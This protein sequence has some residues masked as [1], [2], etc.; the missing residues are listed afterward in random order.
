MLVH[1]WQFRDFTVDDA[2]ISF[3][4]ARNLAHGHGLVLIPGGER[5]EA[6]SNFFWVLCLAVGSAVG[7]DLFVWAHLLGALCAVVTILGVAALAAAV[8]GKPSPLD[9]IPALLA[10]SL[11]PIPYWAM[12][13]LEGGAYAA[14]VVWCATALARFADDG[15]QWRI[16]AGLAAGLALMR[17]DGSVLLGGAALAFWLVPS[18]WSTRLRWLAVAIGPVVV[19]LI[20]RRWYYAY[21]LPNTFYAKVATPF[22]LGQL[23]HLDAPGWRYVRGFVVRYRL[24]PLLLPAVL[25]VLPGPRAR[26]ARGAIILIAGVA[27]FPLY[28]GADWMSE[29][30]FLAPAL[31]L[32]CALGFS[33]I[34]R[35][36]AWWPRRRVATVA[37]WTALAGAWIVP[38]TLALSAKRRGN[39]PAPVEVVATRARFYRELAARHAIANAS[40]LDGDLGATSLYA[41]MPIVDLGLLGDV[42]LARW[43]ADR[44]VLREYIHHERE[45][46]FLRLQGFWW[47]A[48]VQDAPEF[49][50][51]YGP[52]PGQPGLFVDRRAFSSP[53]IDTRA[54]LASFSRAGIDVVGADTKPA[55]VTLR[56][57]VRQ[58]PTIPL[59]LRSDGGPS[60]AVTH[61]LLPMDRWRPGDVVNVSLARPAGRGLRLC[62]GEDCFALP[63]GASGAA[64][65]SARPTEQALALARAREDWDAAL[66]VALARGDATAEIAALLLTRAK[67]FDR[68]GDTARAFRDYA[69]ALRGDPSLAGARRRMEELRLAARAHLHAQ[70]ERKHDEAA[71]TFRL[72]PTAEHLAT[73]ALLD[74]AVGRS[75]AAR[76]HLATGV[77]PTDDDGALALAETLAGHGFREASL[78]L[79]PRAA[80]PG[81]PIW[82]RAA[83]VT[84]R[85][86]APAGA[87]PPSETASAEI[88]PGLALVAAWGEP[89]PD[90]QIRLRLALRRTTF[91]GASLQVAGRASFFDRPASS[92]SA[93][94][95]YLHDETVTVPEGRSEVA[96]GSGRLTVD[97]TRFAE[98]FENGDAEGWSADRAGLGER[99]AEARKGDPALQ[100]RWHLEAGG[101]VGGWRSRPLRPEVDEVCL[102]VGGTREGGGVRLGPE[103]PAIVSDGGPSV[104]NVCLDARARRGARLTLFTSRP[105]ARLSVDDLSCFAAGRPLPCAAS[106][107]VHLER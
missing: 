49:Q 18:T 56:L 54:P 11:L 83:A 4:Y 26:A 35:L 76:L 17:P 63:E 12:S 50:D 55:F 14:A 73:L 1:C 93:G 80:Q 84:A 3:S 90:G 23:V 98:D 92:W 37:A 36:A 91:V 67:R 106:A 81:S 64:P 8:R 6:Y 30:R 28:A 103:G 60:I 70:L 82:A 96:V 87:S 100:G 104:K 32:L 66:N 85:A 22:S 102:S 27:V 79:L 89:L 21:W 48:G 105:G 24:F 19:H 69:L 10:S 77:R 52:I 40:A 94:E 95:V 101:V 41:G 58:P 107:A 45:P 9:A 7:I 15:R 62:D 43:A 20:W 2:A 39:Y 51:R 74:A 38:H 34:E 31:P 25:P 47:K 16:S 53:V 65:Y 57:L 68:A 88:A 44:A 75:E 5:V 99:A 71:R 13:G 29:G 78:A 72:A 33:G 59:R 42:T 61:D 97:A 86:G 46:T